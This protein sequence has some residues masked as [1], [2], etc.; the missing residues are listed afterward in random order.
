MAKPVHSIK[1]GRVNV[2]IWKNER[3]GGAP[4][5]VTL[6][7][8]YKQGSEW[9]TTGS[10]SSFDLEAMGKALTEAKSFVETGA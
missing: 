4:Y 3:G 9:K 5:D 2:A 8:N 1:E 10:F 7:R 6:T